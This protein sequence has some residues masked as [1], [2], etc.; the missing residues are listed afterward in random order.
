MDL[1][2]VLRELRDDRARLDVIIANLE[3]LNHSG[4]SSIPISRSRRG[5]KSMGPTERHEVSERM[6]QYWASRRKARG[7]A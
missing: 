7:A 6:K 4:D 5:R 2:Q 3:A 1:N